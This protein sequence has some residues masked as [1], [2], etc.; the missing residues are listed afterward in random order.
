MEY[1]EDSETLES[2]RVEESPLKLA[3][4]NGELRLAY[5]EILKCLEKIYHELQKDHTDD[6]FE[7]SPNL[8]LILDTCRQQTP[9]LYLQL[10]E[11]FLV[12]SYLIETQITELQ[13]EIYLIEKEANLPPEEEDK[14]LEEFLAQLE[15]LGVC[16]AQS[17]YCYL[18]LEALKGAKQEVLLEKCQEIGLRYAV[19]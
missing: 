17:L 14:V 5:E 8:T 3:N 19:V 18:K 2:G 6:S 4:D 10:T 12:L 1:D 11:T 13:F 16:R 15:Y 9:F 7:P